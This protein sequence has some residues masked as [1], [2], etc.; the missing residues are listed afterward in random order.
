MTRLQGVRKNMKQLDLHEN[1]VIERRGWRRK[2][3]VDYYTEW[4]LLVQ[5]DGPIY[6]IKALID[7]LKT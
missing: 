7:R 6:G 2:I 1:E 5:V 3:L 4:S